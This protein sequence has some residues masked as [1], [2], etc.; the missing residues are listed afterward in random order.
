[1]NAYTIV[2]AYDSA[3]RFIVALAFP[4]SFFTTLPIF[5][6]SFVLAHRLHATLINLINKSY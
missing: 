1:M 6:E 2:K 5:S 3:R 4:F